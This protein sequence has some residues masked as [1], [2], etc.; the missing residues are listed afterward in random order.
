[1]KIYSIAILKNDTKPVASLASEFELSQFGYFQ[2]GS[3]QEFMGFMAKTV[4]E[5]TEPGQRQSVEQDSTYSDNQ[6][7]LSPQ[8]FPRPF[9]IVFRSTFSILY[10]DYIGHVY[11]RTEGLAGVLISDK[12]Y[13][14]RVAFSVLNKV[15]DE[16]I[17]KFSEDQWKPNVLVYP[18]LSQYL[19][20]YQDPKQADNIMR[21]QKELDETKIILVSY[22]IRLRRRKL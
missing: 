7:C 21:V 2:R 6:V 10:L 17:V 22:W 20:K 3:V 16:F 9:T 4:A 11:A 5:R 18:E 14:P 1:M 8:S 15:L 12:E 13:P 19:E